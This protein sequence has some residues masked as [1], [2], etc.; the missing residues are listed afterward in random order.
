MGLNSLPGQFGSFELEMNGFPAL[1]LAA[2]VLLVTG[3]SINIIA[4]LSFRRTK[5]TINP[6]KPETA[7]HLVNTGI[8]RLT[9][10][11]MYL[12]MLIVLIAWGVWLAN[13]FSFLGPIL[14]IAFINKFQIAP[15]EQ[16]LEKLFPEEF[17]NFKQTTRRWL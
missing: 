3:L 17:K 12:G 2:I 14:F 6:L 10:N 15:E 9:R 8:Y 1:D 16:A 4:F 7:S 11:P 5:T 13:W